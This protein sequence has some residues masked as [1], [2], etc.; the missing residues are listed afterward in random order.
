MKLVFFNVVCVYLSLA[1]MWCCYG[2]LMLAAI[3][4]FLRNEKSSK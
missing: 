3:R 1:A 2:L 4:Y